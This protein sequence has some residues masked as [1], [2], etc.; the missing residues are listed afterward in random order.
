[1]VLKKKYELVFLFLL[2]VSALLFRIHIENTNYCTPDS[3]CYLEVSENIL[4][5]KGIVIDRNIEQASDKDLQ[6]MSREEYFAIWPLGYPACI[7]AVSYVT[8]LP[9]LWASKLLNLILLA[10]DFYLLYLLFSGSAYLPMYYFCSYAMLE[11]SSYTW[12]ENLFIPFF[13]IF[14]LSIKEID[15]N[16]VF[17]IKNAALLCLALLG[18]FLSRYAS[19]I[20]YASTFLILL[21]Y[22]RRKEFKKVKVLFYGLLVSTILAGLYLFNNYIQTG[23]STGIPRVNTQEYTSLEL[24]RKFFIGIFNQLHIIKQFGISGTLDLLFYIFSVVIQLGIMVYLFYIL[25]TNSLAKKIAQRSKLMVIVA[26]MYLVFLIGVTSVSTIDPFDYRTL[27]PFSFPV[28]I[29]M[30]A[31]V[32]ERLAVNH[33]NKTI[34]IVKAFFIFSLILNLPKKYLLELLF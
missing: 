3:V 18:M 20:F 6:K 14:I 17:T 29:V 25:A 12:S 9:P 23:Y 8:T 2:L 10:L 16:P 28:F 21:Y 24:M 15:D 31:E 32:E 30:L 26:L 19:V 1:M 27:L 33:K 13:L 34:I 7:V 22:I 4:S 11:M 5:G